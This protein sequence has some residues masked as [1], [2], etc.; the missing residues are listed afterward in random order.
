MSICEL[1]KSWKHRQGWP[2]G[3]RGKDI[4]LPFHVT[5]FSVEVAGKCSSKEIEAGINCQIAGEGQM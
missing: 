3:N 1:M 5:N 2:G 4:L